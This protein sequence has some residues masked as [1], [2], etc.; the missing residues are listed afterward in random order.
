MLETRNSSLEDLEKVCLG[1]LTSFLILLFNIASI[2]VCCQC[3]EM[4]R[5]Y[6]VM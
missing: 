1:A 3:G 5:D 6:V 2:L 4:M